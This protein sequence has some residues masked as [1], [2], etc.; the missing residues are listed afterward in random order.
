M[1]IGIAVIVITLAQCGDAARP[2]TPAPAAPPTPSPIPTPTIAAT[3]VERQGS[4]LTLAA[5][6]FR[7]AGSNI[8]WLGLDENVGGVDYPSPFRVSDALA[9]AREMGATVVRTHAVIS[10]GCPRCIKPTLNSINEQALV[11]VDYAIAAAQTYGLRLIMPLVD[12]YNYYHGGTGTF[13]R[14]RDKPNEA[15]YTDPE[16]IADFKEYVALILNRV[17]TYTGVAYKDDPTIMAWE[18][19]NEIRPPTSWTREI[20]SYIKQIAPRQL[21]IDGNVRVDEAALSIPAVDIYTLHFYPMDR[22]RLA[23][24]ALQVAIADKAFFVGEFDWSNTKGGDS[25]E[26]FLRVIEETPTIAGD[27]YWALFGHLDDHGYV[28][29][30]GGYKLHYPGETEEM[31][32][33]ARLLRDHAYVMRG[34]A[35][36]ASGIPVAPLITELGERIAW[37]GVAGADTYSIERAT[38]G[39]DGPWQVICDRCATDY[40]TPWSGLPPANGPAWYRVRAYNLDGVAGPYSVAQ[41]APTP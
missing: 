11:H 1:I 2:A 23:A 40:D 41:E 17:N 24:V 21:I 35:P 7:F 19:G 13:A 4:T 26:S 18:T 33:R 39:P 29:S 32:R 30:N 15:F 9:T 22:S 31:R 12:N 34:V 6:P 27:M 25:L 37:R 3:F 10:A 20:A 5:Q 16:V 14:W 28:N 38:A 8:Y 36:P